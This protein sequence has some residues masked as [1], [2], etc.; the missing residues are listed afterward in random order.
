MQLTQ[1]L[2]TSVAECIAGVFGL[3]EAEVLEANE[4][5]RISGWDSLRHLQLMSEVEREFGCAFSVD[6]IVSA[7]SVD[8]VVALIERKG[9]GVSQG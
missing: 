1:E 3:S 8:D 9:R 5:K 6:D 2:R 4:F 7:A